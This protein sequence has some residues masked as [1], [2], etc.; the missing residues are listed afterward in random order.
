MR[1]MFRYWLPVDD[2]DHEIALSGDVKTI[3]HAQFSGAVEFWAEHDGIIES[4]RTFR[5]FGTGQDIPEEYDW[6]GT[7][8]RDLG[9]VWHLYEKDQP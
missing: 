5:V 1:K 2:Q 6:R 9:L 8:A 3:A 7:T 4:K